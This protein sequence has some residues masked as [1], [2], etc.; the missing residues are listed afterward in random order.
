MKLE[1]YNKFINKAKI[2]HNDKF[3]YDAINYENIT[4]KTKVPIECPVHGIFYQTLNNHIASGCKQCSLI[5]VSNKN[6][7]YNNLNIIQEK[8]DS[9]NFKLNYKVISKV[10]DNENITLDS[11]LNILCPVHGESIR[12]L[13]YVIKFLRPCVQC[14]DKK[15][16]NRISLNRKKSNNNSYIKDLITIQN[17]LNLKYNGLYSISNS[18]ISNKEVYYE[19]NCKLHGKSINR[20]Y[21]VV[22]YNRLCPV[23]SKL[24]LKESTRLKNKEKFFIKFNN[25]FPQH[26]YDLSKVVYTNSYTA[27]EIICPIHGSFYKTPFN[28]L[29]LKQSCTKCKYNEINTNNETL[30]RDRYLTR[31]KLKHGDKYDYSRANFTGDKISSVLIEIICPKHG[32]FHQKIFNHYKHG[33][34]RCGLIE[35]SLE[36]KVK[37]YLDSKN[38]SFNERNRSILAKHGKKGYPLELDIVLNDYPIAIEVNGHI[39]HSSKFKDDNVHMLNKSIACKLK[40][41]NL[42]HFFEKEIVYNFNIVV[43][44]ID[45]F[46]SIPQFKYKIFY[47]PK[48]YR[49]KLVGSSNVYKDTFIMDVLTLSNIQGIESILKHFQSKVNFKEIYIILDNRFNLYKPILN[50]D[51]YF[52]LFI[53]IIHIVHYIYDNDRMLGIYKSKSDIIST[54]NIYELYDCGY[55][56]Y[57]L[58]NKSRGLL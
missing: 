12:Q 26:N 8:I 38:I 14:L 53:E 57:K 27:I 20:A 30:R 5:T 50:I 16:N 40:N 21:N 43:Q 32:S 51:L 55:K 3:K 22:N 17:N 56:V 19:I 29:N 33:C 44:Y 4:S 39:W 52:E 35:S 54:S 58:T 36:E 6:S 15:E 31:F 48:K 45:Y 28:I 37:Y 25:L 1:I 47:Y 49:Y 18:F 2:F 11:K 24:H 10:N 42:L 34:P 46:T 9:L 13:E 41:Y 23:C 7:K